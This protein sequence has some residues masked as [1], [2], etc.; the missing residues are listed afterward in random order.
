MAIHGMTIN[1]TRDWLD[2]MYKTEDFRNWPP[3]VRGGLIV[4]CQEMGIGRFQHEVAARDGL[5][6]FSQEIIID[7]YETFQTQE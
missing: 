4:L 3:F 1:E 2:H 5:M 7:L 6:Q